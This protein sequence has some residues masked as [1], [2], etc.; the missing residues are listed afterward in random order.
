[1][2]EPRSREVVSHAGGHL[3]KKGS[4]IIYTSH[5]KLFYGASTRGVWSIGSDV[6]L[7]GP[8]RRGSKSKA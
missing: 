5:L 1:M 6:M 4:A 7:K 2:G 8:A 3:T